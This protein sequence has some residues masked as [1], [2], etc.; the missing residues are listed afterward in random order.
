MMSR[1]VFLIFHCILCG[2]LLH[3]RF[4]STL[5]CLWR[6]RRSNGC[7]VI[8]VTLRQ[9]AKHRGPFVMTSLFY[10]D[11]VRR[12]PHKSKTAFGKKKQAEQWTKTRYLSVNYGEMPSL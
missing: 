7:N 5:N 8:G 2:L 9:K 3:A 11:I 1:F 4:D 12:H 10:I 6:L